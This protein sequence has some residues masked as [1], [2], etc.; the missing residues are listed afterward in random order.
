VPLPGPK[1]LPPFAALEVNQ[2]Q[3]KPEILFVSRSSSLAVSAQSIVFYPFGAHQTFVASN[4]DPGVGF[5]D[6]LPGVANSFTG[7]DESNWVTGIPR[8]ATAH[9]SGIYPGIDA[10]YVMDTGG[11]LTLK[12]LLQ[13]GADPSAIVFEVPE[14][15]NVT[16]GVDGAL[17]VR[18]GTERL[19]P[20]LTYPA[21]VA[22]QET[23][24]GPAS[25]SVSFEALSTTRFGFRVEEHNV[26]LPLQ[27]EIKLGEP[28]AL[29]TTAQRAV[30]AAGNL[31]VAETIPD[32]AGKDDPFPAEPGEGCASFDT[33]PIACSDVAVYKISAAGE[34]VFVSYLAGSTREEVSFLGLAPDGAL[35]V[36]GATDSADFP[37]T[38]GSLQ[39]LYAGPAAGFSDSNSHPAAGDFFA[40]RIDPATGTLE[41][42]TYLGGPDADTIGE[43]ALGADG[44][45]YLMPKFLVTFGAA[46][47]VTGGALQTECSADPCPNGYAARIS[48]ALDMLLYGTYLPG[49]AIVAKL[50]SD[51]SV[52]YAG[53]AGAGFPATPA[54][55]QPQLAREPDG[56]VARLDPSGSRLLFATYLGGTESDTIYSM[57][58]ASDGSVWAQVSSFT[59]APAPFE[60]GTDYRL[61]RLDAAGE[62]ILADK[63]ISVTDFAVDQQGNLL[64]TASGGFA[65]GPDALLANSCNSGG[66]IR[67]DPDGNQLFATYLPAGSVLDIY[68]RSDHD[69]PI[70]R[71]GD[72]RF[73]IVE[74]ESMGVFA[75]CILDAAS[76]GYDGTLSPGQVVTLF[77]SGMGPVEGVGFQLEGGRAP[78]SL[79]GTRLLVNGEA[80][81]ILFA[82]Y[83]QVNAILPYSLPAGT[84]PT[85]HVESDGTAGNE[86][87]MPPLQ[88]AAIS[89]FRRDDSLSSPAAA[90]NE[91]GT[92]NSPG[93][94]AT[95]GSRVVLFGTGGGPTVPPSESG[96]VTPLELRLLEYGAAV[97][98]APRRV[99]DMFPV[100]VEYAGAAPGLVA[101]VTQINIKLPDPLPEI[102]GFPPG[103]LFLLVETPGVSYHQDVVTIAVEP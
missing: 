69:L 98:F 101:G 87:A 53:N 3:A 30:D 91:D 72:E 14:A 48:P 85:I 25:R 95:K 12:L 15:V 24:S 40:V 34:L 41:T 103:F 96:E 37:V 79:G 93:N 20:Y 60:S 7:A 77:G 74:D 56:I 73:E 28:A 55:Y 9:L 29:S 6:P 64:A 83:W 21:P 76:F 38:A 50:H 88:A 68:H 63:P 16:A 100:T 5:L 11:Q 1:S 13:Q 84:Q 65:V 31:F 32:S 2:G 66:Y 90:L 18:L 46:L 45:V 102:E 80:T 23:A 71:I 58:L 10:R 97:R 51:G 89:L 42:S 82:S 81:P 33:H 52:Y 99:A 70:L 27:I 92:I 8:Y 36:T 35:T 59:Q 39:T 75:G 94:P 4:P 86:L 49:R 17:I 67:L 19:N 57:A 78:T 44:S 61:V 43:T 26:T 22:F 62:R 47:P 54:A